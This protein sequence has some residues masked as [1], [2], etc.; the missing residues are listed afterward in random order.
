MLL[1]TTV[2]WSILLAVAFEFSRAVNERIKSTLQS[3]GREFH[4]WL[5]PL[6]STSLLLAGL[7]LATFGIIDLIAKGYGSVSWGFFIIYSV[8][9]LT[10]GIHKIWVRQL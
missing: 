1:V 4:A 8:P 2:T 5:R 10:L 7:G 3:K 6:V 9:L